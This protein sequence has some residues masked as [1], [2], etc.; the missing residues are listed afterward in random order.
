MS[1]AYLAS[2]RPLCSTR[3]GRA[4][5]DAL[6]IP[7]FVDGSCRREPDL[8]HEKP[9][10]SALC[11][12]SR[13]APRLKIGDRVAFVTTRGRYLDDEDAGWRLV[14]L[15]QVLHRFA[16]H[17]EAA[18]WYRNEGL[19]L[20]SNCVIPGNRPLPLERTLG[21][22]G[23][24]GCSG[25]SVIEQW[26]AEYQ[27]RAKKCPGFLV[28]TPLMVEL[29][30]PAKIHTKD[31]LKWCGKVPGTQNPPEISEALWDRL[32]GLTPRGRRAS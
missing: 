2:F 32:R 19:R 16:S 22:S 27:Q 28:C 13:F 5:V 3:H 8:E 7:P 24:R 9:G 31:W 12:G 14:A 25:A 17:R 18:T 1:C 30:S 10:I 23:Y 29:C 6:E 21:P 15:L 4:A 26:D 11:R 20:P